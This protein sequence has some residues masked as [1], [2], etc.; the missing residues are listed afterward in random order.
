MP[1]PIQDQQ[2]I[3]SLDVLRGFALL[4]IL[5]MNIQSFA[6]PGAAY[7]NP[8]AFGDLQGAN[9][10][11][12]QVS[13][14]LA[15]QKF[16]SLFSMLFG[17]GVLVFSERLETKG[18]PSRGLHYR[19]MVWL[20]LFG[21]LH[22]YVFWYGDIL[23]SYAFCGML[24]YLLRNKGPLTLVTIGF[25]LIAI[26]SLLNLF[27]GFSME[28][29]P[30]KD[31]QGMMQS[32]LPDEKTLTAEIT[33]Y[34]GSLVQQ[35]TQ[36]AGDT[37]FMQSYVFL[38]TFLWRASGMMLLGMALYKRGF[39]ALKWAGSHYWMM[40]ALGLATGFALTLTGMARNEAAQFSMQ[41]SMFIGNQFNYWGS[42]FTAMGYAALVMLLCRSGLAQGLQ[43]RL[44]AVGR[45][46]FSNYILHTLICTLVFYHLGFFGE[47][48]RVMQLSMVLIIW[49]LQLAVS[50]LWLTRFNYGPMEWL[51]RSLT[52]WHKQSSER[53]SAVTG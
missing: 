30:E 42:L 17:V 46:A 15:D 20:L 4:G 33:A 21:L 53:Q 32:W 8:T 24:V 9:L 5:L 7:I 22:G 27:T 43:A 34:T 47:F 23:F 19:R 26:S 2:R 12:W 39:F 48:S 40:A 37:A 1:N 41:Y 51:W 49:A 38:T 45:T 52:Y 10:I 44:A 28:H 16:M 25:I 29:I 18:T 35:F 36:R 14:L 13:H 6:M 3:V 50:P 31:I 11:V